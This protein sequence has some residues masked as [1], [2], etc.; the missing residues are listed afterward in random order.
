MDGCIFCS[1][2]H[3]TDHYH[4]VVWSD[5][6]HV[7]FLTI[8]PVQKG[9]T[10]VVPKKHYE[11]AFDMPENEYQDLLMASRKV[12]NGIREVFGSTRVMLGI[13]GFQI[14][15]VHVHLV[16]VNKHG[17]AGSPKLLKLSDEEMTDIGATL[18][19]GLKH[20]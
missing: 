18:R 11:Y 8:G 4:K 9:H 3:N 7:A 15:H 14:P 16:P 20:I 2:A 6:N 17:D 5:E 10:L 12:A 13:E 19:E 1:I